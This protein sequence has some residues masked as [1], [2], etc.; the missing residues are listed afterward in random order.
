MSIAASFLERSRYYLCT[1]YPVK[2]RA[3]VEVLPDDRAEHAVEDSEGELFEAEF[4]AAD[5]RQ[6]GAHRDSRHEE[7]ET[8]GEDRPEFGRAANCCPATTRA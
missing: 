2:I 6:Q 5:H 8:A 4:E 7:A 3:A 1:E